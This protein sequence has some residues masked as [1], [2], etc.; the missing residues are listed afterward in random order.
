MNLDAIFHDES[1]DFL[2]NF[3]INYNEDIEIKIRLEKGFLGQVFLLINDEKFLMEKV[4][5]DTYFDYYLCKYRVLSELV[6]YSFYLKDDKISVYYDKMGVSSELISE[7]QFKLISGFKTPD[8]AKGAIMYQIFVD[9]FRKSKKS[10][11]PLDDE[12]IYLGKRVKYVK[13]WEELPESFDV[14]RFYGGDL[15]GVLEKLDY[16]KSLGVEVIYFNPLFVS[17]SNHKYDIQDYEY[18]DPHLCPKTKRLKSVKVLKDNTQALSY[19]R[20]T[21]VKEDLEKA[22]EFF[23]EFMKTL[24]SYGFKVIL[25]GV[26]N[27]CGSFN[28]WLDAEGIYSKANEKYSQKYEVGAI[29]DLNSKYRS[30]FKFYNDKD[31]DAWWGHNT[32]PKLNYENSKE[33]FEEVMNVASKWLLPPFNIDGWRLDVAA[34]LGFS[35]E[36]NH[37]FWQ[38]FRKRVKKANKEALILAEHYEDPSSWLSGKEWDSIMNY[39]AF[40]EPLT[41]FLT[42]LEKHSDR[43]NQDLCGNSQEFFYNLKKAMLSLP[44]QSLLV[45]MNELSNHDHSRFLTRTNKK[46]GRMDSLG[47]FSAGENIDFSIFRQAINMQMTLPGAPTIYYGD[48][49]GVVGFTD[50]DS[51][52]TFPWNRENWDLIMY[53]RYLAIIHRENIA[54]KLGSF[55]PVLIEV[56]ILAYARTYKDNIIICLVYTGNQKREIFLPVYLAS[57]KVK[58]KIE[59]LIY[60]DANTYIPGK[61]DLKLEDKY[62][63]LSLDK[64]SSYIFRL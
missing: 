46:V 64:N 34:D 12:Y 21:C 15:S 62:L 5:T 44:F 39:S 57:G 14:H 29:S 51:R 40:M 28:K 49:A 22:N 38:E 61:K 1:I 19:I 11:H 4:D 56:N 24:H 36:F 42:G 20:K 54:L 35:S 47:S 8:W 30:Y 33:L 18:I 43:E 31:Y 25:D 45:A 9:R 6:R 10:N 23:A 48:E 7:N 58:D 60:T 63:R 16:L 55:I 26:F 17:P 53:Y 3:E 13:N 27:H 41:W 59:Q 52:R 2:S 32:L 37:L 50:P